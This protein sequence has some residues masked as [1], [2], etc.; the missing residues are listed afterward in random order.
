MMLR[1]SPA[2]FR[3]NRTV[4]PTPRPVG[5]GLRLAPWL[6]GPLLMVGCHSYSPS[7]EPAGPFSNQVRPA[8]APERSVAECNELWQQDDEAVLSTAAYW[9]R[10]MR[11]AERIT[12]T[13]ARVRAEEQSGETWDDAFRQ[14]ILLNAA[15]ISV[16]ERRQSYQHLLGFRSQFPAEIYPLFK[17]WRQQQALRLM[18]AEERSLAQKQQEASAVQI[19]QLRLQQIELQRKLDVTTRKLENLTEI[20]RRLSARKQSLPDNADGNVSPPLM[21]LPDKT[22]P[23]AGRGTVGQSLGAGSQ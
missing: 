21:P 16:I 22:T 3:L 7:H 8:A 4:G 5:G 18:L 12:P 15:G 1:N 17:M 20:E 2:I 11:C 9:L 6:L 23:A 10:A 13:Q 14:S 19:D